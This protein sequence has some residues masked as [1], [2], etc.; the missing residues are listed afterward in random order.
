MLQR[1]I[2]QGQTWSDGGHL[3][4]VVEKRGCDI[5]VRYVEDDTTAYFMESDFEDFEPL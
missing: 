1:T 5:E 2:R 3:I 4:E